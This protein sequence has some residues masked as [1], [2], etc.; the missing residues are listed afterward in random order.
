MNRTSAIILSAGKGTR[1]KSDVCKQYI[2]VGGLP[3]LF[4]ALRA[5]EES[6]VEEIIIVVGKGDI[7]FV[8]ND[9]VNKYGFKKVKYII[10]G[11][12]ERYDSVINGLKKVDDENIVLIHDGARPLI[13][14]ENINKI[15]DSM[16]NYKACVAAMPVKDTIKI[17]DENGYVKN[18][19][20]RKYVW[21]IQ[22]PQA[23]ISRDI[24]RAYDLMKQ[25]NDCT[26]TD[27]SMAIEK[28]TDITV[29]LIETG[30]DNIKITTPEDIL[31]MENNI[32]NIK[33]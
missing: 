22:T 12:K 28:Y 25:N 15:I 4:Y 1:M 32:R 17:A 16:A 7:D 18:T 26:I 29:K 9:I 3:I 30:Y 6:N 8:E 20:E 2:H 33:A 11:G 5:F 21:Q 31:F 13:K 19:P 23:F 27:D 14:K 24:K 10:E